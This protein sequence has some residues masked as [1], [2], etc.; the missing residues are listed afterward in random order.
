MSRSIA[1][2]LNVTLLTIPFATMS[3]VAEIM[4][5]TIELSPPFIAFWTAVVKALEHVANHQDAFGGF[6]QP[7]PGSGCR[8]TAEEL[9]TIDHLQ[10]RVKKGLD[11]LSLQAITQ[12]QQQ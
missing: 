1:L 3:V 10:L 11:L 9:P 6:C 7:S 2:L 8:D 12:H 5:P 4:P